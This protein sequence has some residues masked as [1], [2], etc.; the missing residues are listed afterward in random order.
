MRLFILIILTLPIFP[1]LG[2]DFEIVKSDSI[3]EKVKIDSVKI[4]DTYTFDNFDY[5]VVWYENSKQKNYGLRLFVFNPNGNLIYK[6]NSFMD[7]FTHNLTFFK[8]DRNT[9]ETIVL[10]HSSNEYSWGNEVYLLVDRK[11]NHIGLLDIGTFDS[12]DMPWDISSYTQI[13][14]ESDG[15]KFTFDYDSLTY[16][17][18]G[19]NERILTKEQIEYQYENGVLKEKIKN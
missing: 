16:N 18:G 5:Y 13:W 12:L 10:G 19:R 14:T 4:V 2:Q 8:S 1:T 17:P 15:L 7:S 11:F 9:K 3:V 6:S